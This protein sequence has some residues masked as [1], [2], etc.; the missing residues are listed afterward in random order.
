MTGLDDDIDQLRQVRSASRAERETAVSELERV[1]TVVDAQY[2]NELYRFC[3][4]STQ[5][6]FVDLDKAI[7]RLQVAH[8]RC[9]SADADLALA[10]QRPAANPH[11]ILVRG[12]A[13]SALAVAIHDACKHRPATCVWD[14]GVGSA[15]SKEGFW[16]QV[17]F[18]QDHAAARDFIDLLLHRSNP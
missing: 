8:R 6:L 17:D 1:A 7:R 15:P 2:R 11:S 12:S 10:S 4:P 14:F 9:A 18:G 5:A 13:P 16:F 3:G